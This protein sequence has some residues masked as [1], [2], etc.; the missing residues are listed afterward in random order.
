M[1]NRTIK[2]LITLAI[3]I[4]LSLLII[5]NDVVW[6]ILLLSFVFL[7]GWLFKF[8]LVVKQFFFKKGIVSYA[9]IAWKKVFVSSSFALSKR[10]II[11][12]ISGFFQ[13]RI[14]KPLI[15]P[16]TR[17]IR[18]RWRIF[19]ASSLWKKTATII[20]GTIPASL[21]I[22]LV[23]IADAIALVMKSFSLA[24]F[25]TLILKFVTV[26]LLF[27]KNLWSNW[28]QPYIDII[29]VTLFV[30]FIEKI[31]FIGGF[32]RRMRITLKWELRRFKKSRTRIIEKT[33]DAPVNILSEKIHKHVDRK[34][35]GLKPATEDVKTD[36]KTKDEKV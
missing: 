11:N 23:G 36:E 13:N 18:V 1:M 12:T 20:F 29:V 22:W 19:K 26:F 7:K 8:L 34:K 33:I 31:P 5:F 21:A 35:E 27:F 4:C 25:L 10:A 9:T 14:V 15:H 16:L 24:K 6:S 2:L 17:Y 3:C 32:F 30:T 28:I